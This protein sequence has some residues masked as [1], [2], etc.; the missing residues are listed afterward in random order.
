MRP[1]LYSFVGWCSEHRRG[2]W[3]LACVLVLG[4]A[5]NVAGVRPA[6]ERREVQGTAT[7]RI[8]TI[9]T[10][11]IDQHDLVVE[12]RQIDST[13]RP[14]PTGYTTWSLP[15]ITAPSLRWRL[16]PELPRV[17]QPFNGQ[18]DEHG[19]LGINYVANQLTMSG[20]TGGSVTGVTR[21]RVFIP[22]LVIVPL[23][24]YWT[25]STLTHNRQR[26]L[27]GFDVGRGV[28]KATP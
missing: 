17:Q 19:F 13:V 15:T 2:L 14:F 8:E 4:V 6:L 12:F 1:F 22:T 11:A 25:V 21:V 20:V 10:V 24:F 27:K 23:A 16:H 28:T 3:F 18:R 7:R 9:R 5:I 26:R